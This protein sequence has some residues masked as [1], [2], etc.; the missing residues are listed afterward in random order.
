VTDPEARIRAVMAE[1]TEALVDLGR[2]SAAAPAA[3][4]PVELMAPATFARRS[5]LGRSTVYM[6]IA[7]GEIRSLKV[8]GRRL[9]PGSELAR[10]AAA[11]P[12]AVSRGTSAHAKRPARLVE[13]H[14]GRA[15]E[16]RRAAGER[17]TTA[18]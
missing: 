15:K 10:L 18:S 2:D 13:E 6:E 1:L 9:I 3:D 8:R 4:G 16:V 17:P 7:S 12:P 5:G 14:A 11:A